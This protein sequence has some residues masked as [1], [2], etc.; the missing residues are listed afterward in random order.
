MAR[1]RQQYEDED[2]AY[3]A[4]QEDPR[5]RTAMQLLGMMQEM[6][7]SA[8]SR[9]IN[10]RQQAALE[11]Y[12]QGQLEH[13]AAQERRL[14]ETLAES[15]R[16]EAEKETIR[17][18]ELGEERAHRA[19]REKKE[20]EEKATKAAKEAKDDAVEAIDK[21]VSRQVIT[22]EEARARYDKLDPEMAEVAKGIKAQGLAKKV[23]SG[24]EIYKTASPKQRAMYK[25]DP[26]G[27]GGADV[28]AV[29]EQ[30]EQAAASKEH[31]ATGSWEDTAPR[32]RLEPTVNE[33]VGY[34]RAPQTVAPQVYDYGG[35]RTVPPVGGITEPVTVPQETEFAYE[36]G[37]PSAQPNYGYGLVNQPVAAD[38]INRYEGDPRFMTAEEELFRKAMNLFGGGN[39]EQIE[40][41][42]PE[43]FINAPPEFVYEEGYPSAMPGKVEAQ[44]SGLLDLMLAKIAEARNAPS[45]KWGHGAWTPPIG[46]GLPPPRPIQLLGEQQSRGL[47]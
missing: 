34:G 9:A 44:E 37:Y 23:E 30:E 2:E 26:S 18:R 42:P 7:K 40:A 32:P 38:V 31:G 8:E 21:L 6:G 28:L 24:R 13:S 14:M 4:Q 20:D 29:L 12:Q 16:S 35:T 1:R 3:F 33:S 41:V 46:S 19:E 36:E 43:E 25:K 47:R 15:K 39:T 5:A 45:R 17:Q 27:L 10:E 22:P 11:A